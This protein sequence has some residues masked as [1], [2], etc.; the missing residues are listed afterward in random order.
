MESNAKYSS[1]EQ[2]EIFERYL[3]EKMEASETGEFEQQLSNDQELKDAYHEFKTMVF[4]VEEA[5][6]NEKIE[7]FHSNWESGEDKVISIQKSK[8]IHYLIAASVAFLIGMGG[9]WF[10][11]SPNPNQ[12]LFDEYFTPDPGL[13]TVMGHSDEYDFYEA[14]VDYKRKNYTVAIAKWEKLLALKPENDT[15]NY[16]LG[17]ARL[18]NDQEGI[19]LAFLEKTAA[20]ENSVFQDEANFYMGLAHLKMGQ[21]E[22]A[23]AFLKKSNSVAAK[24]L[25]SKVNKKD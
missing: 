7:S 1:P 4:A 6:L 9:L 20:N 13:P 5:A 19:S 14:M 10:Y 3:M 18:A 21:G 15:L 17:S 25:I 2:L 12:R 8:K 11:N 23:K 24:E 22:K 16:F